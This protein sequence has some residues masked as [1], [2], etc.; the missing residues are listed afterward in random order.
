ME[1]NIAAPVTFDLQQLG[2][3]LKQAR[4]QKNLSI[5][6]L[7]KISGCT[8]LYISQIE[9]GNLESVT[10]GKLGAVAAALSF[11]LR[12]CMQPAPPQQE[13]A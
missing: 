13:T 3:A 7:A 12:F 10:T 6:R 2:E 4:K 11:E 5:Y 1:N 8:W 9:Q